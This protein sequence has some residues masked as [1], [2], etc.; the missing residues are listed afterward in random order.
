MGYLRQKGEQ[1]GQLIS[2]FQAI[3]CREEEGGK[4][5]V[6]AHLSKMTLMTEVSRKGK[7]YKKSYC[8]RINQIRKKFSVKVWGE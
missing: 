2:P 4:Q 5:K 1:Q 3:F 8:L 7:Y 6:S